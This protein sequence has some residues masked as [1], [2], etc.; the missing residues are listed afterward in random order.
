MMY[1]KAAPTSR[2]ALRQL[3][4]YRTLFPHGTFATE[5]SVLHIEALARE[6]RRDEARDELWALR[7]SHPDSPQLE[8]LA[9]LVG[10]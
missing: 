9:R 8:H 10:E 4:A 2:R 6:G 3:D 5:A 1:A 7:G